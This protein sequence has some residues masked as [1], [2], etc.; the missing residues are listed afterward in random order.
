MKINYKRAF[1]SLIKPGRKFFLLS[2]LCLS[3]FVGAQNQQIILPNETVSVQRIFQEIEKQTDLSVDYNQSRFNVNRNISLR[4]TENTLSTLMEAVLQGTGFEYTIERGHL[5]IKQAGEN[6][7][8]ATGAG[9]ERQITGVIVD[10]FGEPVI[11]ANVVIKGT[12]T[13]TMSNLDGEFT[14]Q[15]LPNAVLTISYIG[16]TTQDV[17]VGNRNMLRIV[18]KEDTQ[19]LDDIVV[20]GY[21][22]QKKSNVT[23]SVASVRTDDFRDMNIGVTS[24][25]QGRIPGVDINNGNIVIRGAASINGSDPLWIVDGVSGE[26]PNFNDI[27][28]I[29]ILKDAASTA[30]Y[31]ARGAGGV[32]LV[33]TKKGKA[34]KVSVNA[35]LN[36]G[37]DIPIDI[38][39]MLNTRD[40]ID[41]KLASG[42]T[43]NEGSGWDNPSSL[44]DTDWNDLIWRNAFGQ[45]YFVQMTGGNDRTTFN[46]STEY[47]KG[48]SIEI[49]SF[50]EKGY[51]RVASQTKV[52]NRFNVSEVLTLGYQNQ[53]PN[54]YGNPG[55]IFYRQVST[56]NAYDP[57]NEEGGWGKQPAGGYYEGHNPLATIL[58][59]HTNTKKYSGRANLIFDWEVIDNLKLQA[60]FSGNFSSEAKN[61]FYDYWNIGS[62]TQ[63]DI[64]YKDYG[65]G[66]D[67][68][69][70]YTLTYDRT[71]AEKHYFKVLAGYEA[72]KGLSS[73]ASGWKK[74]FSVQPAEDI[75]LGTG[76][77]D[78]NGG[79]GQS[80]S[81]SMFGRI[82]YAYDDKYMAEVS[83]RRDGYDNFGPDNRYG[84]FPSASAGWNIG[85]ESFIM[86]NIDWMSQLKLRGSYGRLVIIRL[87]NSCMSRLLPIIICSIPLMTR[88]RNGVFGIIMWPTLPSNGKMWNSGI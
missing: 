38:P 23:G 61:R 76:E 46:I 88:T 53:D 29:E 44:P 11:G 15:V 59:A 6:Q 16:Y 39:K 22:V 45:T 12:T 66:H 70:L 54:V 20:V 27:E 4:D 41:R 82:N 40:F 8:I 68:R 47:Q 25:I 21:G 31:G 56:M 33:T 74:G 18:L 5:I 48:E 78:I 10:D 42:F 80:R 77:K 37:V 84:V 79:K 50:N 28:S 35:R 63:E 67:M 75:S 85:K 49:N 87:P 26:A 62:L 52:S 65:T 73:A 83:I 14:L 36:W 34:G 86:D 7:V 2:F 19:T 9:T 72:S 30:I 64:Y 32:I 57:E 58:S 51:V 60:N 17:T 81:I 69:M 71:F 43:N 3:I 55:M 1:G 13:G 24:V